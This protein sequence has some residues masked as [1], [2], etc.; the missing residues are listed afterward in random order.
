MTRRQVRLP[1]RGFGTEPTHATLE[2]RTLSG[3]ER[4]RRGAEVLGL[5]LGVAIL[6]LPIPIVHF[7]VPPMAILAGLVL[8]VRRARQGE[9]IAAARGPCP[10]CGIDQ[11][12]GLTGASYRLPRDLKCRSC[13]RLLTL[14]PAA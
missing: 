2:V 13:L 4:L 8:G 5:G 10:F 12:L 9:V 14:E 6:V 1:I 7:A 11:T 3:R